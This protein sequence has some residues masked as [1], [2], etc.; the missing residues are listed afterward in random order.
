MILLL[1]AGTQIL[2]WYWPAAIF[3]FALAI[4]A[5][6]MRKRQLS[7]YAVAQML[8]GRLGLQDRLSTVV[9]FRNRPDADEAALGT[10][11]RQA[12]TQLQPA[13]VQR[14]FPLHF[15]KY[16]YVGIA[17]AT[18][19]LG[20]FGIRYLVLHTVE[21]DRPLASL[22]L[23]IF[24]PAP[25]QQ[26]AVNKKSVIQ[27]R[28]EQQLK[29]LGMPVDDLP[30][31][32][33]TALRPEEISIP[34]TGDQA[35]STPTR[36]NSDQKQPSPEGM[37]TG[38]G[39]GEQSEA[40]DD[41]AGENADAKA[42]TPKN[43]APPKEGAKPGQGNNNSNLM[44]KMRDA[45]SNLMNKLKMPPQDSQNAQ[46]EQQGEGKQAQ[47]GQQSN[48]GKAQ[49]QG[50]G[51]QSQNGEQEGQQE[52]EHVASDNTRSGEKNSDRPGGENSKSGRG[53]SEG[54]K[55]IKDAEQLAAMGK[56]SELLGKRSQ[57]LTGEMTVEVSSGKQ[58][59]KTA[60]SERS[61]A[62]SDT[63]GEVNRDEIPL[64][65]QTYVQRYFQALRKSAPAKT[66]V[67][68]GSD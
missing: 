34:G 65:Y 24:E 64:A 23:S 48:Q 41:A 15:P 54:D 28:L 38:D 25:K 6:R 26:V 12:L 61:A 68:T 5:W 20:L 16:G 56:L 1:L 33:G 57:Q 9:W 43:Q 11:E 14:A 2:N 53:R 66:S 39:A 63:G 30:G 49:A 67:K 44:N 42:G 19:A 50:K 52:G 51:Q 45:L 4:S 18:A 37:E 17:L 35:G 55:S 32:E 21:L 46:N 58:Q 29:E 36:G 62:H 3:A 59:L 7:L 27:E 47:N 13:D 22:D 8:D 10:I 31:P 60:W 40:G